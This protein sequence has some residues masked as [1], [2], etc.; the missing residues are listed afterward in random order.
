VLMD[1]NEDPPQQ[2]VRC[3]YCS[4]PVVAVQGDALFIESRHHGKVHVTVIPL[5]RLLQSPPG[6]R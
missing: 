6:D 1:H 5:K 2:P 4:V 3:D